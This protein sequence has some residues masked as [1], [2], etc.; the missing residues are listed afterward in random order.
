MARNP[1]RVTCRRS[2]PPR[3][4][5]G[6]P[7][8]KQRPLRMRDFVGE[9]AVEVL[10]GHARCLA[11]PGACV[12]YPGAASVVAD[13]RSGKPAARTAPAAR[14]T[15]SRCTARA[16]LVRT[17][18]MTRQ[19]RNRAMVRKRLMKKMFP[20][21]ELNRSVHTVPATTHM[22]GNSMRRNPP[23]PT[24][25]CTRKLTG[26]RLSIWLQRPVV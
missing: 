14:A 2:I 20:P 3:T 17:P 18:S 19:N 24:M 25:S 1:A 4:T 8:L 22:T 6:R 15:A 5:G 23:P 11:W 21:L 26:G 16:S 10:A 9:V 7:L 13:T 12:S